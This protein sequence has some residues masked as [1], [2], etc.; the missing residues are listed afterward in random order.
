MDAKIV[1]KRKKP[2]LGKSNNTMWGRMYPEVG[3]LEF[4]LTDDPIYAVTVIEVKHDYVV[5]LDATDLSPDKKKSTASKNEPRGDSDSE[6]DLP[7]FKV[8]DLLSGDVVIYDEDMD[9]G[10]MCF[11]F[12]KVWLRPGLAPLVL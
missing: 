9:E 5:V 4:I 2:D 8:G 10:A 11:F 1:A 7:A 3:L 12:S 6:W